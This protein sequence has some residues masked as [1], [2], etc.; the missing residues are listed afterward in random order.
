MASWSVVATVKA[1]EDKVLAFLAHHLSLGAHHIH[2]YFDDPDDPAPDIIATLPDAQRSRITA[3]RCTAEHW[4]A[5]GNRQERHQNRQARNARDAYQHCTADW[6]VHIDVD[7]FILP[8]GPVGDILD[9]ARP[10]EILVR[11]E[12]FEAMH[13]PTLTDDIYTARLFRGPIKH[14][15]W[16]LRNPTLGKYRKIMRDGLL[17]HSVGKAFFRAGVRGLAP[18]LHGGMLRGTRI[19]AP[20]FQ[21][22]LRLLHFHAQDMTAWL[23]AVPFRITRGAYQY[24]PPLQAFLAAASNEDRVAFYLATQTMDAEIADIFKEVGIA[25]EADLGLRA[26]VAALRNGTLP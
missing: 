23:A 25:V 7:E 19:K 17:S 18:R 2:I 21:P 16:R 22:D 20:G 14:D 6:L 26:K 9:T 8:A 15:F 12:P 13:D 5:M 1:A 3:T 24:N 10:D 4:A 11:M